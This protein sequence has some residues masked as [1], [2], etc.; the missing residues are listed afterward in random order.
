MHFKHVKLVECDYRHVIP[1]KYL[2]IGPRKTTKN[3]LKHESV[4]KKK[5]FLDTKGRIYSMHVTITGARKH[6]R[7]AE[8]PLYKLM[9]RI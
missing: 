3:A 8:T 4:N 2:R 1:T 9:G 7:Y 5:L 6:V